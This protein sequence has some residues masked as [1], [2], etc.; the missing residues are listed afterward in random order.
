VDPTLPEKYRTWN[1]GNPSPMGDFTKY[2]PWRAPGFAPTS[3]PCGMGG[4]Y[5]VE[6]EGGMIPAGQ[7]QLFTRGSD[8][9]ASPRASWRAG[10]AVEVAWMVGSNHGAAAVASFLAAVLTDIYLC[11]VC[12]C[13]EILRRN[14]R[15]QAEVTFTAYAPLA[16]ASLRN[17]SEISP[18]PSWA[19]PTPSA[20]LTTVPSSPS[21]P[22]MSTS[23]RTH[24]AP[25]G[26]STPYLRE[27]TLDSDC[28]LIMSTSAVDSCNCVVVSCN[29]DQGDSCVDGNKTDLTRAYSDEGPPNPQGK[30]TKGNS[31]PTGTQFPVPFP[32]GYGMHTWYNDEDGPS[33]NMWAI[34][35]KVRS[36]DREAITTRSTA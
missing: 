34:V 18:Y 32:Y 4:A 10:E 31:C 27:S 36:H 33:R 28:S 20:I 35:D 13:Q 29:C 19:P 22:R 17:A 6:K 21:L 23:A 5:M 25:P 3:D 12:S 7:S 16:R 2:H 11:G 24:R 26:A 15:G 8:L 9:P 30:A 1:I 14:G